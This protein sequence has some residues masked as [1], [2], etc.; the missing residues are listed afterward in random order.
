MGVSSP[1]AVL[2]QLIETCK[3]GE[4]GFRHAAELV[5]DST[6]K[7]LF[8]DV[9]GQRARF[10]SDLK[11]HVERFGAAAAD[12][13]VGGSM[14]RRWMDVR[15]RLSGHDDRAILAEARRGDSVTVLA[16]KSAVDGALPATVRELVERQFAE[17][18]G[19]HDE[20]DLFQLAGG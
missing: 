5:T 8:T 20:L 15:D 3:D 4:Q 14:H 10:V 13:T 1:H 17:A 11:P 2:N 19:R 9:A 16:F 12:G 18:R 7:A 6:L